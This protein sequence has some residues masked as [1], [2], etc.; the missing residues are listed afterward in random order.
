[1]IRLG[2]II[3]SEHIPALMSRIKSRLLEKKYL[4][5]EPELALN[6]HQE[7][8]EMPQILLEKDS[9]LLFYGSYSIAPFSAGEIELKFSYKELEDLI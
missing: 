2:K 8:D 1:M 6:L 3:P 9:I 5:S 7:L 4:L